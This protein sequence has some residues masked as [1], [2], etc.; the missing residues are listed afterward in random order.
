MRASTDATTDLGDRARQ[1]RR[2]ELHEICDRITPW[3]Y[4]TIAR[5][6]RYPTY[7]VFNKVIVEREPEIDLDA[8]L[9]IA[10]T[11]L[12]DLAHRWIEFDF[13]EHGLPHRPELTRRGWKSMR[14]V[15]MHHPGDR[16]PAGGP[17]AAE[18]VRVGYDDVQPLKVAWHYEDFPGLDPTQHF[19]DARE[20]AMG[21]A[22]LPVVLAVVAAGEPVGFAQIEIAGDAAEITEVYI[23]AS[24]RGRGLG[25]ALTAA[26]IA[27]APAVRDLWITADA[28]DRPQHLYARM[29]F[30]PVAH[31]INFLRLPGTT[32]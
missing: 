10:D 16:S 21:K 17:R 13:Q 25:T 18:V 9:D 31:D 7:F 6:S 12:A 29:G 2:S 23:A 4:G 28:D 27:H 30:R 24:H 1:W 19:A 3:E 22:E 14:L 5:A 20:I 15:R 26:A 8:M 11:A 32:P